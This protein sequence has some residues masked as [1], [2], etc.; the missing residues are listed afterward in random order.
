[1]RLLIAPEGAASI[2]AVPFNPD[3]QPLPVR[4]GLAQA[5]IDSRD[6]LLRFKTTQR[7]TYTHALA[8]RPDCDDVL[9]WNE[10]GELTESTVANVVLR[11]DGLLVTPA[12]SSGLLPGTY[13]G[14]L[15]EQRK[16]TERVI[17]VEEL[18]DATSIALINA[19]RRWMAVVWL[20]QT[21]PSEFTIPP[22]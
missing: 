20:D 16:I 5:P 14:H 17:H 18:A 11:I 12:A 6:P 15:L 19:V 10:R 22:R 8:G 13:R 7:D 21:S 9:L 4:L 1:V 3:S 2:E